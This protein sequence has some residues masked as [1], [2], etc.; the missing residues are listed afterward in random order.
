MEQNWYIW[1]VIAFVGLCF[2][3]FISA[4]SW[5]LPREEDIFLKHSKCTSCNHNL[6]FWDLFPVFSWVLSGAKCRYC[7]AKVSARY[8]L[9]EVATAAIFCYLFARFGL[10]PNFYILS[11]LSVAFL[12]MIIADF[13]T[14]I[15]PDST[16]VITAILGG[17]YVY[18]NDIDVSQNIWGAVAGLVI[19][20][21]LRYGFYLWKKKESLGMG[22]VKFLPVAG[23]W[24]GFES[25]PFYMILS[26]VLG[27]LTGIV[28]QKLFKKEEYPFGPAL[29][30]AAYLL[31]LFPESN[32]LL[33]LK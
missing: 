16:T 23:F 4:A 5:R 18:C 6:G 25:M 11:G 8:P 29:A 24:V 7:K 19:A 1:A 21:S 26:G 3:S 33:Q 27:V 30:F 28:W 2:G 20:L 32:L 15:I 31:V 9:T 10:T 17:L 22:D 12:V 14:Y 13:E